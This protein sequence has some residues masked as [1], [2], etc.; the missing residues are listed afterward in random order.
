MWFRFFWRGTIHFRTYI[1]IYIHGQIWRKYL[2]W[3][4]TQA[5]LLGRGLAGSHK[6]GC[7]DSASYVIGIS[8]PHKSTT[9][10]FWMA[11]IWGSC[12]PIT[13]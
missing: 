13:Y 3:I 2:I 12:I 6:Q 8:N 11:E 9:P 7:F 10:Y 5:K 4:I 1:Y